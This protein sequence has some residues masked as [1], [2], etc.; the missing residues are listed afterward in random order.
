[1]VMKDVPRLTGIVTLLIH[2]TCSI[3]MI[4]SALMIALYLRHLGSSAA[5]LLPYEEASHFPE[6][7]AHLVAIDIAFGA[8]YLCIPILIG[9]GIWV[10]VFHIPIRLE[11]VPGIIYA[12]GLIML[13]LLLGLNAFGI[14]T[15]I[16]G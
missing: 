14:G 11:L 8:L 10:L 15:W 13:L 3:P 1:M 7:A 4:C 9:L 12:A 2:I 5:A 16:M 6:Y